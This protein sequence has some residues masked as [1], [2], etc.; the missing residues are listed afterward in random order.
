M[1][2]SLWQIII[3]EFKGSKDLKLTTGGGSKDL[4]LDRG[5]EGLGVNPRGNMKSLKMYTNLGFLKMVLGKG[6]QILKGVHGNKSLKYLLN[7]INKRM[8]K[9]TWYIYILNL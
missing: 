3:A 1:C 4:R 2:V 7:N 9:L 6:L 8:I 5:W